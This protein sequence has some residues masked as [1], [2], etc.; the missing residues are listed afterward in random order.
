M[1]QHPVLVCLYCYKPKLVNMYGY[2]KFPSHVYHSLMP[3]TQF[4]HFNRGLSLALKQA[5]HWLYIDYR[6]LTFPYPQPP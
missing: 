4:I 1:L 2:L 3:H 5:I 6:L